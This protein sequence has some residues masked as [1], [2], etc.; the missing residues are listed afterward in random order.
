MKL[1]YINNYKSIGPDI[2]SCL[3]SLDFPDLSIVTGINGSGKTH[4][5]EAI[6]KKQVIISVEDI[7]DYGPITYFNYQTFILDYLSDKQKIQPIWIAGGHNKFMLVTQQL[8]PQIQQINNFAGNLQAAKAIRENIYNAI[9]NNKGSLLKDLKKK[10]IS[11]EL[12]ESSEKEFERLINNFYNSVKELFK[13]EAAT[14]FKMLKDAIVTGIVPGYGESHLG[15]NLFNN[16][17]NYFKN[18]A[19]AQLDALESGTFDIEEYEEKHGINPLALFNQVLESFSCNG[20]LFDKNFPYRSKQ[21]VKMNHNEFNKLRY[22]PFLIAKNNQITIGI[23]SLSSGEKTLLALA[24]IIHKQLQK[25]QGDFINGVLLLDEIDT[26][27]HP[28]MIKNMLKAINDIFVK[29][30][31]MKTIMVTHSPT[32]VALAPDDSLFIMDVKNNTGKRIKKA[33]KAEALNTLTEGY[34]TLESG[35]EL[36]KF[37]KE[38]ELVI[39]T[40]GHNVAYIEKAIDL[41]AKD[42]K[43]KI[44][45]VKQFISKSGKNQLK[46]Y[47][48][49]LSKLPLKNKFLF[50]LDC[51]VDIS[52]F[53][54][55]DKVVVFKF[56]KADSKVSKGIENLFSEELFE[57]R[58][59]EKS[60]NDY[61]GTYA[62][63]KK[64]KFKDH[65]LQFGTKEDFLKFKPLIDEI[66]NLLDSLS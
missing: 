65:M 15:K 35:I 56:D 37:G 18:K 36:I 27:L 4:L 12:T 58:F 17:K 39:L 43:E 48:D 61:G 9:L 46:T 66:E 23:E 13:K 57:E 44:Y 41:L 31:M 21:L 10:L 59:Y 64:I 29:K 33:T 3:E 7:P 62:K 20:Y 49:F 24:S 8:S 6:A 1:K 55:A 25:S 42:L 52:K 50:V 11:M 5:L 26:N 22:N 40:E 51:D 30:Y 53:Q 34:A 32:T 63:F 19:E 38:K 60:I 14:N 47:F 2:K 45:I 28:S 54:N 16:V